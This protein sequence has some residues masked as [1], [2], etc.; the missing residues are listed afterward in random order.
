MCGFLPTGLGVSIDN[1]QIK[2]FA[3][4]LQIKFTRD[5]IS[6]KFIE[7]LEKY[8]MQSHCQEFVRL[9]KL[10]SFW[11]MIRATS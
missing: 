6:I 4:C 8:K 9:L 2:V 3:I 7:N 10:F 5:K 1:D 11:S